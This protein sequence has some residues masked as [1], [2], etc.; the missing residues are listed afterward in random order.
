MKL[1]DFS[2]RRPIFISMCTII[3][4][5]LGGISLTRLPVDLM[6]DIT[7][8]VLSISTTYENAGPEEIEEII[9]RPI[10]RAVSAV[11]GVEEVTSTS[12]EGSSRVTVRFSYET[13]LDE[14]TNDI[15]DRLDRITP[16]FPDEADRP[17]IR[18][19]DMS[20]FPILF[21]GASADLDPVQL[22]QMI[23]DNVSYRFERVPGVASA[24]VRG[25]RDRKINVDLDV[26]RLVSS[27]ISLDSI[28]ASIR[29]GTLNLSAG[30]IE[31]GN[32]DVTVR[33]PGEY[34]N[35]HEIED[36]VVGTADDEMIR[37]KDLG[38]VN[39]HW[40]K[41]RSVFPVDGIPG[42]R[43]V[44]YK[45]S[46][47]NTVAVAEGIRKELEQIKLDFPQLN[48]I[49]LMDS[50]EYIEN[51]IRNVSDSA[52][53]GSLLAML[54]L[55]FFLRDLR[56]TFI[57]SVSIPISIVATFTLMFFNNQSV[58][59]ITL[60][61]LAL[62][63]GMLVDN[64]I[65]VLENIYRLRDEEHKSRFEA[66][67]QGT[68]EVAAPIIASTLTTVAVFLPAFFMTGITG[69]MFKQMA[70]V[71]VFSLGCS[72]MTALTL[73]PMMTNLVMRDKATDKHH[74]SVGWLF[75]L[76]KT[77]M[78]G[79]E[80]EYRSL[81]NWALRHR[82]IVVICAI[83]LL[84]F[85]ISMVPMI[86]NEFMP[87]TDEDE[88]RVDVELETGTRFDVVYERYKRLEKLIKDNT[89]EAKFVTGEVGANSWRQ[90]GG[91]TASLRLPLWPRSERRKRGLRSSDQVANDLRKLLTNAVP[92]TVIRTRPGRGMFRMGSGGDAGVEV[93]IR[94]FDLNIANDLA[95]EVARIMGQNPHLADVKI[96]R[97]DGNPEENIRIDRDKAYDM[98]LTTH[99]IANA[100][101][102]IIDGNNAGVFREG[103][104]EYD[105]VV[106]VKDADRMSIN[107]L[108][109]ISIPNADGDQVILRNVIG[110]EPRL[111]PLGIDRKN[112]ERLI[113]VSAQLV[114]IDMGT[115]QQELDREF[116]HIPM[117][118]GFAITFGGDWEE[119][120]KSAKTLILG[121]VLALVLVY[122]VMACQYE[123]LLDPFI[124]MFSVPFAL[125]G[126]C[127]L[128]YTSGTTFNLYSY[129]GCIMLAGIVVNNAIILV[130][131]I[132][133]LRRRDGV[134]KMAAIEESGR[135]RLRP[136]LMTT[137]TTVL[138][139][140]PLA[141]GLGDGGEAQA[142]LARAVIG[143]LTSSTL[144]TLILIPVIYSLV[145]GEKIKKI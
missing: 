13:N 103:G 141:L 53:Q 32:L 95:R 122:M 112:Q 144:I 16:N 124:V 8:P 7:Y 121:A 54:I 49:T 79:M 142:P 35:I 77:L 143:G 69:I 48:L 20:S 11:S 64:S 123:S 137:L 68:Q 111:G 19:F 108:L 17:M 82:V 28:M 31:F 4:I 23:E 70:T 125:V 104:N 135:R 62:G 138:G 105:I 87:V 96:S 113:T 26:N 59:I 60:G 128:L 38:E 129:I 75:T 33:T 136:I 30:A 109:D 127:I 101:Q 132:N 45:Q 63:V 120:Q 133:L 74:W 39:D 34:R 21:L 41:V 88:V 98:K 14:A 22:K 29:S 57:I 71:I 12:V 115:I 50:S 86:G 100:L 61:G 114:N 89:P 73:V 10:E 3:V 46:G 83:L 94:G 118:Q 5:V 44:I 66:S 134:P 2:A 52:I 126:V 15:R 85:S 145:H 42:V 91:H 27:G 106:S 102:T 93:E 25:G 58:N 131:Q 80:N 110:S 6:P 99:Q 90:R 40:S 140:V 55:L 24:D 92:G 56:S 9:T 65:V 84:G 117:P 130:D 1:I 107:Q 139:L 97:E 78:T 37:V 67:V 43:I 72:L 51:S 47:N 36:L 18:K 81:L 119:Q 116:A 76:S